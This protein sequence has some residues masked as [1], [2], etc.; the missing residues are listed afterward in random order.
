MSLS[1]PWHRFVP[2]RLRRAP[3]RETLARGTASRTRGGG[4]QRIGL[5]RTDGIGI[6]GASLRGSTGHVRYVEGREKTALAAATPA[7]GRAEATFAALIPIRKSDAWWELPQ[8]ERRAQPEPREQLE[9]LV[10]EV[11]RAPARREVRRAGRVHCAA[12]EALEG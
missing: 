1:R 7:L 3:P 10:V 6:L 2:V 8:D 11:A 12:I 9:A 5:V 4:A